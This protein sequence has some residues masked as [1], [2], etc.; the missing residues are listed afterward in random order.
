MLV[1]LLTAMKGDVLHAI[2]MCS[3]GCGFC[4]A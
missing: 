4:C 3:N 1:A 2:I